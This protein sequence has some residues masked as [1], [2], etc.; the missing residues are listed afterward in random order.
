MLS[1]SL[2]LSVFRM[3]VLPVEFQD[4][5]FSATPAQL[6]EAVRQAESYFNRQYGGATTF[7]FT[8]AERTTLSHETA[9]YGANY[10]D[11]KDIRLADAVREACTQQQ[12]NINFNLY[13]NDSDG[14]VDVV[15]LLTAGPGENVSGNESDIWP[16]NARLSEQGGT[17]DIRGKRIN[18]FAV[19]PEGLP[20]IFRHEFGH[21]LGLPDFYDQDGED[22]G[23]RSPGRWGLSIMDDGCLGDTPPDFGAL[24]YD[25]LGIGRSEPL[26]TG[27]WRLEPLDRGRRYLK[28]GG[29]DEFFLF[30][31]KD[32]AL[33]VSHI[34]RSD[35]PS[36]FDVRQDRVLTARERWQLNAINNNPD[37][38]CARLVPADPDTRTADGIPFAR[39]GR[40]RF[41]SDTPAPF[42]TWDGLPVGLALTG[43]RSESDGSVS[44][45]VIEPLRFTEFSIYQDAA[46]IRWTA[47]DAL[48]RISGYTISWSDGGEDGGSL[49][50][51]PREISGTLE[52]LQPKTGYNVTVQVHTADLGSFSIAT[53]IVTKVYREG[54]YP[55]IYLTNS[56]RNVDGS[57]PSG[58][59][60]P[61]RVFNATQVQEVQ[62]SLN[63]VRITPEA[64]GNYSLR[65][66]GLLAARIIHTDGS[67]ETIYKEI[68]V[69]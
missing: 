12:G 40:D 44:F 56:Q 64:D 63:G 47:S 6:T 45:D 67:V 15:F 20:G 60:I 34:D 36:G 51:G 35:N 4:R 7:E 24:E 33:F 61:L 49:E 10:P 5:T 65:Q 37:H 16:Q 8:L 38:L 23:G 50:L 39:D 28:T 19:C 41:G 30:E 14:S 27:H 18:V 32:G 43:I 26:A 48:S 68:T 9:W 55:Y 69:L 53:R 59:K 42:R 66:S 17:L 1:L 22:S 13:D 46:V 54:T 52:G 21:A 25:L 2:L 31:C 62:W 11:R 57:F 29:E 58:S 3:I